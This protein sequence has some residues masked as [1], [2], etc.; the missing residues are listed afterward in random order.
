VE[1]TKNST[2]PYGT[3]ARRMNEARAWYKNKHHG[4]I[5]CYNNT[6]YTCVC[7]CV[8][9]S[10]IYIYIYLHLMYIVYIIVESIIRNE[11]TR[12]IGELW[13]ATVYRAV[14]AISCVYVCVCACVCARSKDFPTDTYF[15]CVCITRVWCIILIYTHIHIYILSYTYAV[16]VYI[17]YIHYDVYNRISHVYIKYMEQGNFFYYEPTAV[18]SNYYHSPKILIIFYFDFIFCTVYII[19]Y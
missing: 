1:K 13:R 11:C 18:F 4:G 19:L 12:D 10:D 15:I 5:D 14:G 3:G 2:N 17:A 16:Q 9:S 6:V 7:V 8:Y